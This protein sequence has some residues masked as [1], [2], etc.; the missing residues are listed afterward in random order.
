MPKPRKTLK[1]KINKLIDNLVHPYFKDHPAL[2][3][4]DG[5]LHVIIP[6]EK[7]IRE[8]AREIAQ[9]GEGE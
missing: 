3:L 6:N 9:G 2:I 5:L 1:G 8:A 4:A 7:L